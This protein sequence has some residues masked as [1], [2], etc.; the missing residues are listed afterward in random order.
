MGPGPPPPPLENDKNIGFRSNTCPDPLNNHS[1]QAS[2]QC[3]I[4]FDA[5]Q[6][7]FRWRTDDGAKNPSYKKSKKKKKTRQSWTPSDKTFW[8]RACYQLYLDN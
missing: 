6:M 2:I 4:N 7:V 8:I 1:L 5:I 3:W